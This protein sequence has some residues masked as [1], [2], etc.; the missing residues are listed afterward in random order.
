MK[1]QNQSVDEGPN[2]SD[3]E[4]A[5]L[6]TPKEYV[7]QNAKKQFRHEQHFGRMGEATAEDLQYDAAG[8]SK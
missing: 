5:A 4:L 8:M 1:M 3:D 6:A 2:Y 7:A